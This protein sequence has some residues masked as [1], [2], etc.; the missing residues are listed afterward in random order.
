M[1]VVSCPNCSAKQGENGRSSTYATRSANGRSPYPLL[2][3]LKRK[4]GPA[5]PLAIICAR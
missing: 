4:H 3:Y 5:R 1:N 2:F